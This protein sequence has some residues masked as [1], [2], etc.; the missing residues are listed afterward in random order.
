MERTGR[1]QGKVALVTGVAKQNGIG[2][3]TC[4][5]LGQEGAVLA[6]V[7]ISE[8]VD[9]CAAALRE[10]G[11]TVSSH[12]ADLTNWDQVQAAVA[13]AVGC[14]G[15]LDILV[16]NA[17][18][19]VAGMEEDFTDFPH[20][21]EAQWDFGIAINLKTQFNVTRAVINGMIERGYGRIVSVSSVTG[22][23][24]ANPE[25]AAYC[26]AKAGV[27]GMTRGLALD[28]AKYGITVNA[29][30]P[31][32]INTGSTTEGERAGAQNTPF[33][34]AAWPEEVGKLICFLA[35]DDAS[36]ITGQLVVIDGGNTIQEYKGPSELYY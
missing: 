6:I 30:G 4:Q 26:A 20:L 28:V 9:E 31:G 15:R 29:V 18:M 24:V 21:S 17:G 36:Y 27:L 23:I 16:N 8:Q 14:H 32:W 25:E 22:P 7:D 35:S 2:F 33:G 34:R 11:Y 12:V 19:V 1:V 3:A 10:C 5:V 13:D